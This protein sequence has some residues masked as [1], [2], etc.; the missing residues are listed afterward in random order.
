MGHFICT[1][2]VSDFVF[3]EQGGNFTSFHDFARFSSRVSFP[4]RIGHAVLIKMMIFA[5]LIF[6]INKGD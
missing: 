5:I 3:L 6:Y 4:P 2:N 1:F